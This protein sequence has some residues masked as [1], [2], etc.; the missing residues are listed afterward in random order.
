LRE[1][2]QRLVSIDVPADR[3][4]TARL[5]LSSSGGAARLIWRHWEG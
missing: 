4:S 5:Y 2:E 3:D 1:T